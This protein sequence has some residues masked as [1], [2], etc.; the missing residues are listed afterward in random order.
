[1]KKILAVLGLSLIGLTSCQAVPAERKN[2][3]ACLWE[4][5]AGLVKLLEGAML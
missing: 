2:N 1:M 3:C 5:P 4:Y